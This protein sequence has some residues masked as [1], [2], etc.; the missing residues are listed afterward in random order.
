MRGAVRVLD[1]SMNK[2]FQ[3]GEFAIFSDPET[4]PQE[5][6][7]LANGE[8][9]VVER[10]RDD[11]VERSLRVVAQRREG[12]RLECY[13]THPR[14]VESIPYPSKRPNETVVIIGRVVGRYSKI[15]Q[16]LKI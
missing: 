9:V 10:R 16:P 6:E 15:V 14:F 7:K 12:M 11:L 3:V 4:L 5:A 8:I 13:S 1:E 2:V